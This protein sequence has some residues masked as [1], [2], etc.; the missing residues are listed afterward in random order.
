V[1]EGEGGGKGER[2]E[3]GGGRRRRRGRRWMERRSRGV[4]CVGS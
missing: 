1:I 2:K 4:G 3:E